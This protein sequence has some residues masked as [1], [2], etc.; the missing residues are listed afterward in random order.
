MRAI[1]IIPAR[2][3]SE[4]FE[5]KVLAPLLGK[6]LIQHVWERAK[7]SRILEDL[8]I[9]TDNEEVIKVAETFG[10]KAVSF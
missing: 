2:W 7:E 1:G 10:G 5:G 8:I 4:R 6:P 9:A 3:Q